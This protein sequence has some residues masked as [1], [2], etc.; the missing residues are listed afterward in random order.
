MTAERTGAAE[1]A[2]RACAEAAEQLRAAGVPAEALAEYVAPRRVL[3]WTRPATMRPL[4]DVWRIGPL[5]L[6]GSG[7]LYALGRAT[8]AAE[9]G[10]PGYQSLSREERRE[11]AAA[12]LRGGYETG[13][14][15][16]YDAV[17]IPLGPDESGPDPETPEAPEAPEASGAPRA[18]GAASADS[19]A[20]AGGPLTPSTGSTRR[21]LPVGVADGEFRVRWRAGAPLAGAPTLRDFLAERV[22]LL[23]SPPF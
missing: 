6:G 2:A 20:P 16:N 23:I 21:E 8:R 12:A 11:I 9:R 4:G 22:E 1:R 3:L 13:T 5:L 17:R 7:E 10:R 18:P 14:P 15:V 19:A